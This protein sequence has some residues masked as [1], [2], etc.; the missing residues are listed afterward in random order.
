MSILHDARA[1]IE[2]AT[3]SFKAGTFDPSDYLLLV[4]KLLRDAYDESAKHDPA[5][6]NSP[7]LYGAYMETVEFLFQARF[8]WAAEQLLFEWWDHA[9]LRQLS[10]PRHIYR[11]NIALKLAQLYLR[12]NDRGAAL[13]WALLTQADDMLHEHRA[14]GG[15]GKQWLRTMLGMS[16]TELAGFRNIAIEILEK[17]KSARSSTSNATWF[18]EGVVVGLALRDIS[19][20][21]LFSQPS[22]VG[23]FP[24]SIPYIT[25]LLNRVDNPRASNKSKGDSLEALASY[26]FLLVPGWVPSP[27]VLEE[28]QGFETDVIVSNLN[29]TGNLAAELLGRHFLVECKNRADAVSVDDVGYFLYRMRLTHCNFGVMFATRGITG[30]TRGETAARSIIRKAFHE[31]GITCIVLD[32]KN[33]DSL[34]KGQVKFWPLLLRE[35]DRFRFGNP[36]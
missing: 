29:P 27:N 2:T 12:L 21:H 24:I 18:D 3:L 16:E 19:F 14:G 22:S 25:A 31:D 10:E 5:G 9:G 20:G 6:D 23:E 1:L 8:T 32:R 33:L 17:L 13:R 34:A 15:A 7:D 35:I 11:A 28:N 36:K 30:K 4:S 26:L